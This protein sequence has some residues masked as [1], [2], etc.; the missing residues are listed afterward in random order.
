MKLRVFRRF[1]RQFF[2]LLFGFI[3]RLGF[4]NDAVEVRNVLSERESW[5][6][7]PT[8]PVGPVLRHNAN[9][10]SFVAVDHGTAADAVDRNPIDEI[11][12]TSNVQRADV[13][14]KETAGVSLDCRKTEP[15]DLRADRENAVDWPKIYK[16][17]WK[18]QLQAEKDDYC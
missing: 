5:Q 3:K 6:G 4:R 14:G 18:A 12:V 9:N 11:T 10:L 15:T 2:G 1:I 16:S 8:T 17:L 7:I 13:A